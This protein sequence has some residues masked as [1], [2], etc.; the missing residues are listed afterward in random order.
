M[1]PTSAVRLPFVIGRGFAF[2]VKAVTGSETLVGFRADDD[3][4][5]EDGHGVRSILV[6]VLDTMA[7][8][9]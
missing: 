8:S 3:I 7:I 9:V 1:I 2:D 6:S 5:G 4:D